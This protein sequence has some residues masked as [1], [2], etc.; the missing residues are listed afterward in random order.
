MAE[1]RQR[2]LGLFSDL[3]RGVSSPCEGPEILAFL[4]RSSLVCSSLLHLRSSWKANCPKFGDAF[5]RTGR[6]AWIG[7]S[8]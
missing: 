1:G 3:V 7:L 8:H 5:A 4:F 2:N 6:Y